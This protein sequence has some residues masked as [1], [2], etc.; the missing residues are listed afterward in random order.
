MA[1]SGFRDDFRRNFV[2]GI[3]ALFPILVTLILF[4]WLYRAVDQTIGQGTN[5]V[6]QQVLARD[7]S[8]FR[9]VFPG[10]PENLGLAERRAYAKA[11]FPSFVGVLFGLLVAAVVVYLTGK[12]L[13]GYIGRRAMDGVNRFF[14]RFPVIKAVYPH[15]RQV[16]DLIFGRAGRRRFSRVVAVQY[17]RRGI[18]TIGFQTGEGMTSL[19]TRSG[20]ELASVFIPTSPTPITGM[21]VLVPVEEIVRL[22]MTVDEAFR[23]CLTAGMLVA[24]KR[25][26]ALPGPEPAPAAAPEGQEDEPRAVAPRPADLEDD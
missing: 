19:N 18:Y 10:A 9:A 13:R 1:E 2:T 22:D 15:A 14:E 25:G 17:P 11:N 5:A 7:E 12:V 16:G 21:V 20:K 3:A 6:F 24:G 23:Y 4:S 26:E 8:V